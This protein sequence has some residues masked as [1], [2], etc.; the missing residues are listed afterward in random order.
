[1][2]KPIG[3]RAVVGGALAGSILALASA[4]PATAATGSSPKRTVQALA[5]VAFQAGAVIPSGRP[6]WA[7]PGGQGFVCGPCHE[8]G[9]QPAGGGGEHVAARRG[10]TPGRPGP[11]R[12]FGGPPGGSRR[13]GPRP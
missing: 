4:I 5:C 6:L 2:N 8:A 11:G 12:A 1:M 9:D 13:R 3:R 7:G 10:K